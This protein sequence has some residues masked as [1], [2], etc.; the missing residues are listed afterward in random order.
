VLLAP[1]PDG[2]HPTWRARYTDPDSGR[3]TK[4]RLDPQVCPTAETRRDWAVR[5]SKAIA[6]RRDELDHGAARA[7]NTK[8]DDALDQYFTDHGHLRAGTLGIYRAAAKKLSAWARASGVRSGDDVTGPRLVAFRSAV[9]KERRPAPASGGKRGERRHTGEPRAATTV[10]RELRAVRT[11]LGYLRSLGLLARLSADELAS[12]LKRMAEPKEVIEFMRPPE[13]RALLEAALQHDDAKFAETRAEHRGL[14]PPG[15]TPKYE[16]IAPVVL[17]AMLTGMRFGEVVTLTWP[18]VDLEAL[19]EDEKPTGAITLKAAG[20][21]TKQGR[22]V[23]LDHC[24]ALRDLLVVLKPEGARGNTWGL[25]KEQAKAAAKR[26]STY[27]APGWSWQALRRSCGTYLT[28]APSIFGAASAYRSAKLLGH[29]VEV[30]E[31]HYTGIWRVSREAKT[32]ESA[33][34]IEEQAQQVIAA[35]K[36]RMA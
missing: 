22:V 5:K 14:L 34:G 18:Q 26:L 25:T 36:A 6:K 13:L 30:A 11:V 21:K 27:D 15:S 17:A 10:N 28:N 24:P 35:I 8:L 19:G 12:S 23:A 3:P 29:S 4:V 31:K 33:M 7:T 20:T 16:A 9:A 32:L 1:D 2:R